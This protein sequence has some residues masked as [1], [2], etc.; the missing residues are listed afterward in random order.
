MKTSKRALGIV[1]I[2]V[3]GL[4]IL[5][6]SSIGSHY[7]ADVTHH[8]NFKI[9]MP[10]DEL[11]KIMV[12]STACKEIMNAGKDSK[13]I[14]QKWDNTNFNLGQISFSHPNWRVHAVG[15]LE[16]EFTDPYIGTAL[17]QFTQTVSIVP[18]K[19][20][21][22]IKL[23]QPTSRLLVYNVT[24]EMFSKEGKSEVQQTLQLKI[25]TPAPWYAR[26]YARARVREST[27]R[28]LRAMEEH[29]LTA[30]KNHKGQY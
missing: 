11:R 19:I 3:V 10:F 17:A 12:R 15:E 16:V 2:V 8:H 5:I 27:R 14:S 21:S 13:L 29:I 20:N 18:E 4:V 25:E 22:L 7:A 6:W 1:A 24:T 26:R 28:I 9:D 23:K 30:V